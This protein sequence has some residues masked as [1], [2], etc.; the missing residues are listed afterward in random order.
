[1][2]F[3]DLA[4]VSFIPLGISD[5]IHM[6]L[7]CDEHLMRLDTPRQEVAKLVQVGT[8]VQDCLH[9]VLLTTKIQILSPFCNV[10]ILT[11]SFR[12]P[13]SELRPGTTIRI[14]SK[15]LRWLFSIKEQMYLNE[16]SIIIF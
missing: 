1:M 7:I 9:R 6:Y 11:C 13:G 2:P 4:S 8:K 3:L 16:K 15:Q 10:I 12:I 14:F 5:K